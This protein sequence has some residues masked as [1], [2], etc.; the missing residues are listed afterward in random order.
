MPGA[1]TRPPVR[2]TVR[3]RAVPPLDPP[4]D[5]EYGPATWVGGAVA[6][7]AS[8]AADA[9]DSP[10]RSGGAGGRRSSP[11]GPRPA[12]TGGLSPDA[13]ANA[14]PEARRAAKRFLDT[15]LEIFNGYRPIA[16]VRPLSSPP[17]VA[18]VVERLTAG[19]ARISGR[20]HPGRPTPVVR[21]RRLRVCEPRPGVAEVAA[22]LATAGRTWAMAFRLERRRG[23]W[24]GM[25]VEVL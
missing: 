3:L 25:S 17:E 2:P 18:V 7:D 8:D 15:C 11:A 9:A 10:G 1:R 6:R 20:R 24:V 5:D 16:H 22:V 4:F 19:A 21:L 23:R 13:L 14:T 12:P